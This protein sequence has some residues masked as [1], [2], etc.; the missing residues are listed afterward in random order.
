MVLQRN[1]VAI[2]AVLSFGCQAYGDGESE[3][4][5]TSAIAAPFLLITSQS[6]GTCELTLRNYGLSVHRVMFEDEVCPD[7]LYFSDSTSSLL[8]EH[9]NRIWQFRLSEGE[10]ASE[11]FMSP[12]KKSY[13]IEEALTGIDSIDKVLR[14]DQS[15]LRLSALGVFPD[16]EIAAVLTA[17]LPGDDHYSIGL[18]RVS[19]VWEFEEARHCRRFQYPC[20]IESV[21]Y[22][23]NEIKNPSAFVNIWEMDKSKNVNL[24]SYESTTFLNENDRPIGTVKLTTNIR[25]VSS[26]VIGLGTVSPDTARIHPYSIEMKI[27]S[28]PARSADLATCGAAMHTHLLLLDGCGSDNGVLYDLSGISEALSGLRHVLLVPQDQGVDKAN[29][30]RRDQ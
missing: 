29:E 27:G 23:R 25:G 8:F 5:N 30:I 19:D 12:E 13:L 2:C 24:T 18:K 17:N 26:S 6:G 22:R 10:F 9:G 21:E 20:E 1:V 4:L 15:T 3:S 16:G 28:A 14:S 7:D 11:D